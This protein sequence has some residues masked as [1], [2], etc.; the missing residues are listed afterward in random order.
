MNKQ[1]IFILLFCSLR[2][3]IVHEWGNLMSFLGGNAPNSSYDNWVS[4]VSEGIASEGYN[5]Y[6][7][8][9]NDIQT[10]GFGEYRLLEEGSPT[11]SYWEEIFTSFAL[12]DTTTVDSLLEDS[13]TS[14]RYELVIFQDTS[15]NRV[16]HMLREQIDSTFI[17][18][19]QPTTEDDNVVGSFKNGWGLYIINPNASR[20]QLIIQVPH[21]CDDFIAPYV[22]MDLFNTTDAFGFMIN[23]AG[24]E[25][26]W[27]QVGN[28]SNSKSLSDPSRNPH[29]V[30]QK[31][32]EI[33]TEPMVQSGTPHYPMVFAVHSFDN[34]THIPRKSV[35]LAAGSNNSLTN[36][37]IR[38]ITQD[39]LDIINFTEEFPI[40]ENQFSTHDALHIT[41]YYETYY[42]DTHVFDNGETEVEITWATELR[43]PSN[44]VQMV[45]LHG[46]TDG[47]TPFEP[48]IHVELDEKPMLFDSSSISDETIY[49]YGL[50]PS[51]VENFS[52]IRDFY[53]PFIQGV[54]SYL[55]HWETSVDNT[56]PDSIEFLFPIAKTD[57]GVVLEWLPG[58]D[59]NFKTYEIQYTPNTF[60]E[61]VFV[62][63]VSNDGELSNMRTNQTI[64]PN[65]PYG[66]SWQFR[67]RGVDVF[68]NVGDWSSPTTNI[69]PGHS[70]PDTIVDFNDSSINFNSV[71]DEDM[72]PNH[73]TIDTL[74]SMPG[75]SPTLS[76]FGNTWKS[77]SIDP[78]LPDTQ[79]V[80]HIYARSDS[81]SE[82][83]GIGFSDGE[84]SIKYSL[85]GIDIVNIESWIPVYQGVYI[86]NVWASF[87]LPIGQDWTAWHDTLSP[88]TEIYF[89][90][91]HDDSESNPGGIHF[92]FVRDFTPDLAIAPEIQIEYTINGRQFENA[93]ETVSVSFN[94]I[95]DDVDSY[96]FTYHW[97]FGDGN[98]STVE[99][100]T[101]SYTIEDDHA[102]HV[103]LR[104]ED[105]TGHV[106][107]AT[108]SILV[109]EGES[110]FPLTMNFVGDIMMGRS[111]EEAGG[112]IPPQGVFALF[113]PTKHLLGDVADITVA[114][115]EIPLTNQG[116]PHPTK[117]I[118]FRCAPENVGGLYY[119]GID[120]VSLAN[121]HIL[122]YMEPGIIQTQN[123][124]NAA[125]I[126]HSGAG[127]NSY[128][129]YLPAF[130]S[131]KGQTIAFLSSSDRTGQY[132]NYQPYLQAGEN[133][134][135][136]AYMTPYYLKQQ[137]QSVD[138]LADLTIVEMHA[139]SE[140]STSPG[141]H[142]DSYE[143]PEDFESMRTNPASEVGFQI[144]PLFGMEEEDYSPRLDRP[145]MWDR[146]IRHFAIDEGA[147]A[148]IVHHP[149][150]IQ[151][152]EIY[153]GKMIA[154]S[155][156][157]FIFD[158]NYPETYPS[159]ILNGEADETGF[160]DYNIVPVYL[161]DYITKPAVGE[162]GYYILNN[163]AMR[164]KELDT[165]V[166]VNK[167]E[168]RADVIMDTTSISPQ[169]LDYTTSIGNVKQVFINDQLLYESNPIKLPKAG[170]LL[171]ITDGFNQITHY[172]LG[173]E[174]VWM[175]NFEN[176]G[177]S[178]WNFNSDNEMV[179]DSISRRGDHGAYH[180]RTPESPDNIITNLEGR[181]PYNNELDHSI[182]GWIK[183]HN[184]SNVTL[185]S[186]IA[187]GRWSNT[188]LTTSMDDSVSGNSDWFYYW[189][190][191][192][193]HENGQFIDVRL[194][195]DVPDSGVA[196][197]WFDDVGIIQW[198]SIQTFSNLPIQID[199]PNNFDYIQVYLSQTQLGP[200]TVEFS[201]A[202]IGNLPPLQAIPRAS[203]MSIT[204][205]GFFHLFDESRGPVGNRF[206]DFGE[207]ISG[208][209]MMP[210]FPVEEPGI[211]P[212][213]LTVFGPNGQSHIASISLVALS[214]EAATHDLGDVNGDGNLTA[215]DALLCSNYLLG[216][217]NFS[218][219]EF[220]A[221]DADGNG[222]I[223][224][225]DLLLI[226]D[227]AN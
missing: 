221:A 39:H 109:D 49:E 227:W 132:N 158:L 196:Y 79:T 208:V 220:L 46:I 193:Y 27:S 124:L 17:D 77:I 154:H 214:P 176:E 85:F 73:Y 139:G 187:S 218:P 107:W 163:I 118:V 76:I 84:Q 34:G 171:Q 202:I 137:I 178:L 25:V 99:S 192:P 117:S 125:G 56:P 119:A 82:I 108:A 204:A 149:H 140:Y 86:E 203:A 48:W 177:S 88:I 175:S 72:A 87:L 161:D 191:V 69:L 166:H 126:R 217:I 89:I 75:D 159:F 180:I 78:F 223:E 6:G 63:D 29:T 44:G 23:G 200:M 113:E 19:N 110:S 53:S 64:I 55:V 10:N 133:K 43:G 168:N 188:L 134:S 148:V 123:I 138:G 141:S 65:I 150:I 145:Q 68:N 151:G 41:E 146:A 47:N 11:L 160:T 155:L 185:Q 181:L 16:Y 210:T 129:A 104:V 222:S 92:S 128:E 111:F 173:R 207:D 15:F 90:N 197:S 98:S 101:H 213:S 45:H 170:S 167:D 174:K 103:I 57:E 13:L 182:H 70:P 105:E 186:R 33:I 28:Y 206:W 194:N 127:M 211:Y 20:E 121:N 58:F 42:D 153:N 67:V 35:I 74:L 7:P 143:P 40:S 95:L 18:E 189:G 114:N 112:I 5:Y 2:A 26:E 97:E 93:T 31:F 54:E 165:Y 38:D 115:L 24:R 215:V 102:Y 12:G 80:L 195:S 131:V 164:S 142:Y 91:D 162:L 96:L 130:K 59:T 30:F 157:N 21:P 212:I 22:A 224:I 4:H 1:L 9:W 37:P 50:Y 147:D 81:L 8:D 135:G 225:F 94:A 216:Y 100:P 190:N 183:T 122:D 52:M 172:R 62:W 169:L 83:Q 32:Q 156:G 61:D 179:Q 209:G 51:G 106:G 199:Y 71:S 205:P 116:Y 226:S 120:V 144:D 198:D 14:F 201:N 184:G 152:V 60:E 66:E 36:K 219:E 136:F 3:E